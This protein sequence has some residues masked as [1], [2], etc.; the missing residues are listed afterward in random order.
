MAFF[1]NI[2]HVS[3]DIEKNLLYLSLRLSEDVV[4]EYELTPIEC[5]EFIEAQSFD[6]WKG[7]DAIKAK[8]K[9]GQAT[10]RLD[11]SEGSKFYRLEPPQ[12]LILQAQMRGEAKPLSFLDKL[13]IDLNKEE[14]QQSSLSDYEAF[15]TIIRQEFLL[16]KRELLADLKGLGL[17]STVLPKISNG[18]LHKPKKTALFIPSDLINEEITST[19]KTTKESTEESLED[20]LNKLKDIRRKK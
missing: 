4:E 11:T 20:Q 17:S 15:R 13:N 16:M 12:L 18:P 19:I 3:A 10:L 14:S 7:S 2:Y 1:P 6:T 5:K 8:I 9:D